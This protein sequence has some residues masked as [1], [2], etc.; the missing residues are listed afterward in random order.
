MGSA[1]V[2]RNLHNNILNKFLQT[3]PHT[4]AEACNIQKQERNAPGGT[5]EE[6]LSSIA[7]NDVALSSGMDSPCC[8]HANTGPEGD[9]INTTQK[10][11][12]K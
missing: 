4:F 1:S 12:D 11:Y 6:I 5:S 8:T 10:K 9:H 7:L 3:S 2:L